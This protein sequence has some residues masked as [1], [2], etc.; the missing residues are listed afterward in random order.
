MAKRKEEQVEQVEGQTSQQVEVAHEAAESGD[1]L[2]MEQA[3]PA[4][5]ATRWKVCPNPGLAGAEA[6]VE[7]D[8][9]EDAIRL[10]NGNATAFSRKQLT[11]EAV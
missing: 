9:V 7:A 10:Y 5:P 2:P 6:V 1:V 4:A 11:I 3:A 8:T